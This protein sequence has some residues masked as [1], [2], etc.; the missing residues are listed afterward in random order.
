M[1]CYDMNYK[2]INA[3][4]RHWRKARGGMHVYQGRFDMF[5]DTGL[6]I[7]A[8]AYSL[9]MLVG[10]DMDEYAMWPRW[11]RYED[12]PDYEG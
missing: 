4:E 8:I 9:D 6:S 12:D 11:R 3:I 2:V 10:E 5:E 7:T 1:G